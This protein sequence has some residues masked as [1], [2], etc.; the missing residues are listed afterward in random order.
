[1]GKYD[2]LFDCLKKQI[3]FRLSV[4]F[5]EIEEILGEPLPPSAHEHAAWWANESE[6]Q[7]VQA[8]S[9]LGAGWRV[10]EVDQESK[11]VTFTKSE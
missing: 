7:H 9:W 6:G 2:P 1:M 5:S 8:R 4:R 10:S 11:T 3:G